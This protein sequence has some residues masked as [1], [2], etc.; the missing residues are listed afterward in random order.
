MILA[1][2]VGN[3]NIV[4]AL[5]DDEKLRR[6]WRMATDKNKASDEYGV[7]ITQFLSH[8]S[9][10]CDDITDVMIAS[11]VPT[12]MHSLKN[13]VKRY[14][15]CEPMIVGPGIKTGM[16]IR[17][18]NPRELGA[19]RIVNAVAA[20][21]KYKAPLIIVDFG[22]AT[23]FCAVD[24]KGDYI[25]GVIAAGVK[26]SMDALFDKTAKLPKVEIVRPNGI[27]GRNTIN[28]IQ[29]GAV[30]GQAAQADGIIKRIKK[31]IGSDATVIAT[32]GLAKMIAEESEE[33]EIVDSML[34]L[35][36]LKIL[37]DKNKER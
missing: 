36:G 4:V 5:Y 19:D 31:E 10:D 30:Y 15:G 33:I 21:N 26:I 18:D 27:I 17:M 28:A 8:E 1:I 24:G 32:G 9:V 14:I 3:T 12:V 22:T 20:I 2:D 23:T 11:V 37:Y 25:G 6:N 13:A 29:S 35:D 16:N 7:L 34:T